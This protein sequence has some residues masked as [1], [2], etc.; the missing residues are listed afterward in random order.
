MNSLYFFFG[1]LYF[2][3]VRLSLHAPRVLLKPKK[4]TKKSAK[5]LERIPDINNCNVKNSMPIASSL[6]FSYGLRVLSIGIQM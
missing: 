5:S 4:E 2:C 3:L 6:C 1:C